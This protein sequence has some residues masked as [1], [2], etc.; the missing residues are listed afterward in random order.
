V[1]C[2]PPPEN[3]IV[4]SSLEDPPV[5]RPPG[6]GQIFWTVPL[7][8]VSFLNSPDA[9]KKTAALSADQKAPPAAPSVAGTGR[10]SGAARGRSH[11]WVMP[12]GVT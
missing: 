5:S 10:A 12:A 8:S 11:N 3:T 7:S 1:A 2:S 6:T 9:S 4:P